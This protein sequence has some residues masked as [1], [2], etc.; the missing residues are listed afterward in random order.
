MVVVPHFY[1]PPCGVFKYLWWMCGGGEFEAQ[2]GTCFSH[3]CTVYH[4][5]DCTTLLPCS[6]EQSHS[7]FCR[8]ILISHMPKSTLWQQLCQLLP[9]SSLFLSPGEVHMQ[10]HDSMPILASRGVSTDYCSEMVCLF[11]IEPQLQIS[12]YEHN[13]RDHVFCVGRHIMACTWVWHS[14]ESSGWYSPL[15]LYRQL[16]GRSL[17]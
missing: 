4:Q 8:N 16:L 5:I 13:F 1:K 15:T 6:C 7:V 9:T 12:Q 3:E 2:V 17:P 14:F 10:W 11:H